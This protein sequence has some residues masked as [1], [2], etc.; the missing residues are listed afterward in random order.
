MVRLMV[1]WLAYLTQGVDISSQDHFVTQV[2][3]RRFLLLY[4]SLILKT[5]GPTIDNLS[6]LLKAGGGRVVDNM[7]AMV[8]YINASLDGG[9]RVRRKNPAPM[10]EVRR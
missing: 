1:M 4:G 5:S 10:D 9:L 2:S 8:T 6:F 7:A 3:L